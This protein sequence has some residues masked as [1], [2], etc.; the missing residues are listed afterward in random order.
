LFKAGNQAELDLAL[1]DLCEGLRWLA[2]LLAPFMPRTASAIWFQLGLDG[3]PQGDWAVH[4][5]WGQLPARTQTR[6][7]AD[8]LF[9]RL[10]IDAA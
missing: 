6:P 9:P 2:H 10:D 3:A 7:A 8:P 1:Y 5:Q 4:L